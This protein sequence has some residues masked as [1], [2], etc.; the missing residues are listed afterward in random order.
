MHWRRF[1]ALAWGLA[2]CGTD[3]VS[4]TFVGTV[5]GETLSPA[6]SISDPATVMFTSGFTPVG[7][8]VLS[9]ASGLCTRVSANRD[10]KGARAL[11]LFLSDVNAQDGTIG[12]PA[13]TGAYPVFVVGS[14]S[15]P[16]HF[17]VAAFSASDLLCKKIPDKSAAA[18][19]GSVTLTRNADGAY[20]GSYDLTFD[21]GDRVTGSFDAATCRGLATYLAAN[22]HL[23]G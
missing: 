21:S 3:R 18:V 23:C 12:P 19:S 6:D 1:L 4:G 11:T 5:H 20:A 15:P 13:G 22:T 9:D 10:A 14:G 17:S 16:A 7:A 8:I 2:A